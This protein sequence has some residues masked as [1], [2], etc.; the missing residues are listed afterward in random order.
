MG[1]EIFR[2]FLT[3]FEENIFSKN[4]F[5]EKVNLRF[6]LLLT[7]LALRSLKAD[8][9]FSWENTKQE[10]VAE[11]DVTNFKLVYVLPRRLEGELGPDRFVPGY[12][13]W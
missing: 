4:R 12:A 6:F 1:W 2:D 13:G 5:V 8:E 9:D 11:F 7:K 10:G 3:L